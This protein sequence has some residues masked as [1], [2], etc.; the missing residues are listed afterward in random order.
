VFALERAA[1]MTTRFMMLPAN[2]MPTV[3]KADTN[4][5][6]VIPLPMRSHRVIESITIIEST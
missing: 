5:L 1:V 4:G 3:A 6:P 2:G